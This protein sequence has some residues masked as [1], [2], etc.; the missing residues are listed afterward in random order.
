[1]YLGN[2]KLEENS[3]TKYL[4]IVLDNKLLWKPYINYIK[5]KISST[6]WALSR[7]N[8]YLDTNT[9]I[10]IYFAL[11]YSHITY[12]I[13]CWGASS[14]NNGLFIYQKRAIK[15]VDKKPIMTSSSPIFYKLNL[16]KLQDIYQL[17][18]GILMLK[19]NNNSWFGNLNYRKLSSLHQHNTRQ[20][21]SGNFYIPSISTN[22]GKYCS[23]FMG[24]VIWSNIPKEIKSLS[25]QLFKKQF[26]KYLINKYQT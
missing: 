22:L 17:K 2:E 23:S 19:I 11:I 7:L 24:P 13:I 10:K 18:V 5:K 25:V 26:S 9:L 4:G 8:K 21:T 6:C 20:S 15:L 12:G 14:Y 3:K 16:L 1:M